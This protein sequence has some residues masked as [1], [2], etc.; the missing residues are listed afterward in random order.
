MTAAIG[1]LGPAIG[2]LAPGLRRHWLISALMLAG[3]ALRLLALIA[4]RPALFYIDST[5]YLYSAAG[6]DPVGYRVPLRAILLAGNLDTIAAVQ[7]LLG[8]AMAAAIYLVLLRRGVPRWLS[9]L[10]AAP[11]LLDG[12]QLQIEQTIMPDAWFEALIVAGL[13]LLLWQAQ[14]RWTVIVAAGLALG[15]AATIRQVGEILIVPALLYL[16]IAAGRTRRAVSG[17]AILCSA[18]ALP[19]LVYCSVS[20]AVTG[21]FWLS[22][23]G[24][25]T[26]YG[27]V[28]EAADCASLKLPASERGL[29]PSAQQKLL[30]P[31]GL[32]HAAG[33]PLRPYYADLPHGEASRTVSAFN[34]AVVSQQPVSVL[35]SWVS[36]S[37]KL[38]GLQ[39]ASSAG[40]TPIWRWQFQGDFPAYPPHA[41]TAVISSAARQFGG[42]QPAV[43]RPVALFLRHYQLHGGYTPGPLYAL[44]AA[45]GLIGALSVARRQRGPAGPAGRQ[46]SGAAFLFT[47]AA[48]AILLTS[49][50][51]EFSWRYQLPALVTLP[52]AGALGIAVVLSTVR[53]RRARQAPAAAQD[54]APGSYISRNLR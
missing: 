51:F 26:I 37:V 33:S 21:H 22:H 35:S 4:F 17:A 34:R 32:E 23:S 9:A 45:A 8:L 1:R 13:V 41:S 24:T 27:R 2:R 11:V 19:I 53:S 54:S 38:F 52:P 16:V 15:A 20:Y 39:R 5:R 50:L 49:D 3:L 28:A 14:A 46:L 7:H 48:A 36:D 25:T 40:D 12:Y 29:C 18:F 31:D 6:N 44:A 47:A 42:G 43:D 30:G 10:A